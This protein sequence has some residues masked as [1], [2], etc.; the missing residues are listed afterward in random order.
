MHEIQ[1]FPQKIFLQFLKRQKIIST[2]WIWYLDEILT[3]GY[4]KGKADQNRTLQ[5]ID[6]ITESR[7]SS[8]FEG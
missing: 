7:A 4:Y 2:V 1:S 8:F 3:L 5:C 6:C